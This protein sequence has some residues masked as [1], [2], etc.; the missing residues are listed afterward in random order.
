MILIEHPDPAP[1]NRIRH[2]WPDSGPRVANLGTVRELNGPAP[3][4]WGRRTY[5]IRPIQHE[6]G[7]DLLELALRLEAVF[8]GADSAE[9]LREY[10]AVVR[11]ITRRCWMLLRPRWV[12]AVL[13][14]LR[15]NPFR[16]ATLAE[17]RDI[18][19]FFGRCQTV[20]RVRHR[21]AT[22]R[23]HPSTSWT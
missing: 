23:S 2:A 10:R 4:P 7:L 3:L 14:R 5:A 1:V 11:E 8:E 21:E 13:W 17:V 15:S 9:M 22:A 12:P 18:L 16:R 20:S 19:G 6:D